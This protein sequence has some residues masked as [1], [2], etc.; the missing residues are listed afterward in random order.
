MR[1]VVQRV[2]TTLHD[3]TDSDP[4]PIQDSVYDRVLTG[5]D[6]YVAGTEDQVASGRRVSVQQTLAGRWVGSVN[7][8]LRPYSDVCLEF[9]LPDSTRTEFFVGPRFR[10]H[11]LIRGRGPIP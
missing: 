5:V 11:T 1:S 9:R 3:Q 10:G 6:V 8:D 4:L 2:G 7:A